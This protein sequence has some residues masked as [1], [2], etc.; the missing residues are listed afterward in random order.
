MQVLKAPVVRYLIW[1]VM[2]IGKLEV[3]LG[4]RCV[5]GNYGLSPQSYLLKNNNENWIDIAPL[6]SE[7]S[8]W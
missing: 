3:F 5:P 1:M 7:I 8:V 6:R 4:A 2:A